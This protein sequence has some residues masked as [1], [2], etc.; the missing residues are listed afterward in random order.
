[1]A[2]GGLFV[3][4]L[5]PLVVRREG[6]DLRIGSGKQR[7]VLGA[8]AVAGRALSTDELIEVLWGE[9]APATA[10]GTLHTHVSR[11]RALVGAD[12]VVEVGGGYRL[13]L[14]DGQ[15]DSATFT[16]R[17]ASARQA[18][19][20]QDQQAAHRHL[21][22]GLALWRG[23]A[24]TTFRYEPFAQ[25]EIARLEALRL[26]AIEDRCELDVQTG[27]PSVVAE[28]EALTAENPFRERLTHLL[29]RALYRSGRQADALA[30]AR[31]LRHA[32]RED[33]GIHPGPEIT[34]L[35]NQ[36]LEQD[37]AL[38]AGSDDPLPRRHWHVAVEQAQ[39]PAPGP[40]RQCDQLIE[41]AVALRRANRLTDARATAAAAVRLASRLEDHHRLG[42]AALALAG[43]P[44]DTVLGE[45]L[46]TELLECALGGL[47]P[48]A[49][50]VPVL[51]ARL[52]VG[53]VDAGDR[54]RGAALLAAAES[55]A[56][57]R[58]DTEAELY[59]LR[60]RHRT[61]FEPSALDARIALSRRIEQLAELSGQIED[62]A[63]AHRWLANDLLEAG[64]ID[65]VDRY[66]GELAKANERIHDPFH[67]WGV[68][69]RRAGQ[70]TATGPLDEADSLVTD[71]LNLALSIGSEYTVATT[72]G[73]L[74]VL[75][76]R[77]RRLDELDS[78]VHDLAARE[79]PVRPLVPLLHLE[80]GRRD[81]ARRSLRDLAR[82]GLRQVLEADPIGVTHLMTLTA[83]SQASFHL[84]DREVAAQVLDAVAPIRSTMAVLHPGITVLAPV[85]ELR[86][87]ALGCLGSLDEAI[88]HADVASSLC[89]RTG[90][91]AVAVRTN[92]LLS[93]LLRQRGH[94]DDDRRA[95]RLEQQIQH[96]SETTG[97]APPAWYTPA[98]S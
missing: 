39:V 13:E 15:L 70:R 17:L 92:A 68:V 74:F 95:D 10:V 24:L 91:I 27:D 22:A 80:L 8:L 25:L 37:P 34:A 75:R 21:T 67:H 89:A 4:L 1:M 38:A 82:D 40:A 2:E 43:P 55:T 53:Y 72:S 64:D 52:A 18:R 85:A 20:Q 35:E 30:A 36:I 84:A 77:Q 48:Q 90:S 49:P 46:D 93:L 62:R 41:Q 79:A 57:A 88:T 98:A 86:A 31:R 45:P 51:Q 54:T 83:L 6:R 76:W 32:L 7:L 61:W 42:A 63:W 87:A 56:S 12:A 73:L 94:R 96:D 50:L 29:M 97:A 60:A 19:D 44:E 26:E 58:E 47:P 23:P 16:T 81:E 78:L 65:E 66:L 11:L 5:G 28:L 33:L 71:A 3:G 69:V 9:E 14:G 59:V